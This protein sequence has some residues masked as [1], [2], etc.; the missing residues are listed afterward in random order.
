M[1]RGGK[2][3]R[4]GGSVALDP[5]SAAWSR[6]ALPAWCRLGPPRFDVDPT[7]RVERLARRLAPDRGGEA[8]PSA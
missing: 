3:V 5:P 8:A 2:K 1:G 7:R 6:R 4:R